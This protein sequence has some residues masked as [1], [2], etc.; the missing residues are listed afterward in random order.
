MHHQNQAHMQISP[1]QSQSHQQLDSQDSLVQSQMAEESDQLSHSSRKQKIKQYV[2]REVAKFFG[3]DL[4][5]EERERVKWSDRQK[6]LA[7]RRFGSLKPNADLMARNQIEERQKDRP[8][9]L[10]VDHVPS[11]QHHYC[12][13]NLGSGSLNNRNNM[14]SVRR[15]TLDGEIDIDDDDDDDD[16]AELE[17]RNAA[18]NQH[19]IIERKASV[20][21]LLWLGLQYAVHA[22][23]KKVAQNQRQWS[24]SFAP[25]YLN[26]AIQ[27]DSGISDDTFDGVALPPL[28]EN[29]LFFDSPSTNIPNNNGVCSNNGGRL[30]SNQQN[31][32]SQNGW[33]TRTSDSSGSADILGNQQVA[34]TQQ[35]QSQVILIN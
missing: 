4:S 16:D 24:R 5:S 31:E 3:V 7:L 9:I 18:L 11:A 8:D 14:N 26:N 33:R 28:Q 35:Q 23:S 15:H 2:K 6:R 27:S 34:L 32:R 13:D 10:P 22:F 20:S 25:Q 17:N 30:Q 29:E 19:L 21:S 12:R 1:T